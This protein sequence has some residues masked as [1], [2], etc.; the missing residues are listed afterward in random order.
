MPYYLYFCGIGLGFL[1][2]EISQMMRLSTFLG[3]PTYSLTVVLFT[4]L[5]FSGIGSMVVG[6]FIADLSRPRRLMVPLFALLGL[7]VVFGVLTPTVIAQ[8]ADATTPVRMGTAVGLLAPLAFLMG[9]PFSIGMRMASTDETSPTAFLWGING[10]M[11]VVS[12]VFATVLA[13][14][15]GI[16]VAFYVGVLA[17]VLAAA[18]LW[19]IVGRL[20]VAPAAA[21]ESEDEPA[22]VEASDTGA[23]DDVEAEPEPEA[24][25][26][27]AEVLEPVTT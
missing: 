26:D 12:S 7:A 18:A 1:M 23:D 6:R 27:D 2:V 9:M 15:F 25:S 20:D 24:E 22:V 16:Y 21:A 11:S 3:H 14:F 4:V 17:Y 10:A 8:M 19:R 5:L 13:L